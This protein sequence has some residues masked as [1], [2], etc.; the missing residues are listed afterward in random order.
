MATKRPTFEKR[1]RERDK[2][3]KAAAKRERRQSSGGAATETAEPTPA[4]V[5][6]DVDVPSVLARV[7]E[8]HRR[9]EEGTIDFEDFDEQKRALLATLPVD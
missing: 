8:L 1:Q 6:R 4:N 2:Q 9:F 3:A 5:V 7:D